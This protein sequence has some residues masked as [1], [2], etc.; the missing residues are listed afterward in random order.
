MGKRPYYGAP[1]AQNAERPDARPADP[2]YKREL[3]FRGK[4]REEFADQTNASKRQ[5]SDE[6][7]LHSQVPNVALHR[8]LQHSMS[9]RHATE[10]ALHCE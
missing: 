8:L 9:E 10:D 2:A 1:T 5:C 7:R 3:S 4:G 6:R